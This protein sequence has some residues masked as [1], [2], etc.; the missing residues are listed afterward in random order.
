M[1][2]AMLYCATHHGA[3]GMVGMRSM[4]AAWLLCGVMAC[5]VVFGVESSRHHI[6]LGCGCVVV[7]VYFTSL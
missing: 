3:L 1:S 2:C 7:R 6:M 5:D 4:C